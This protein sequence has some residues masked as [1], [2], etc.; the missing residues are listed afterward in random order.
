[1]Y[2]LININ[3]KLL[4]YP[5]VVLNQNHHIGSDGPIGLNK[6]QRSFPIWNNIKV[7]RRSRERFR[8][9]KAFSQALCPASDVSFWPRKGVVSEFLEVLHT[10]RGVSLS[11]QL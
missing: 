11:F 10:T 4:N 3:R 9:F 2:Y 1:M 6:N 8:T 5:K 7:L